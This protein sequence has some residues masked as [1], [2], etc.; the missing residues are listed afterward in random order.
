MECRKWKWERVLM[1]RCSRPRLHIKQAHSG[2]NRFFDYSQT[3]LLTDHIKISFFESLNASRRIYVHSFTNWMCVQDYS[4][5][6]HLS[7]DRRNYN[8][9]YNR[10]KKGCVFKT[11][12]C[13]DTIFTIYYFIF[14]I[15][16][17]FIFKEL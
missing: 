7:V 11:S 13:A 10:R 14:N 12:A 16:K 1:D 8:N 4:G 2:N 3:K 5:R 6:F 15:C 9:N 17:R